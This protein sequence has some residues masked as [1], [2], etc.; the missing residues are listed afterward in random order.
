MMRRPMATTGST[1]RARRSVAA[2]AAL[3][4]SVAAATPAQASDDGQWWYD[5]YDVPA[6]HAEGWTGEGVKIAVIDAQINPDLPVFDGADLTVMEDPLCANSGPAISTEFNDDSSHGTT[7]TAMLVGNG[8]GAGAERGIAPDA[9]VIYYGWG[10][11]GEETCELPAEVEDRTLTG[12]GWGMLRALEDGAQIIT[13]SVGSSSYSLADMQVMAEAIARGVVVLSAS[14]NESGVATANFPNALNGV[15]TVNAMD[16]DGEIQ[17]DKDT[18][19]LAIEP[20]ATVVAAGVD[21]DVIG[22]GGSWDNTG[23]AT[24]AS[25]ASPIVAGMLALTWQKYP[26]ATA[27]QLVQSLI[28]NTWADDHPL[29]RDTVNGY[30]YGAAS[31]GHLLREDPTQYPDENPLMDKKFGFPN[32]DDVAIAAGESEDLMPV[33]PD[34]PASRPSFDWTS[35]G[36]TAGAVGA[37]AVVASVIIVLVTRRRKPQPPAPPAL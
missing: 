10:L 34:A 32:A 12:G 6:A 35:I 14:T 19:E 24:G 11:V 33:I 21:I 4:L 16:A 13:T 3:L 5:L 22:A 30:G 29:E 18:G 9:S 23:P 15:V 17:K 27:N 1:R 37:V 36:V 31:L 20:E 25:L 7:V 26:E 8:E 2:A 28:H